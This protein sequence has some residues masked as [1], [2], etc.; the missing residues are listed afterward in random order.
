[1]LLQPRV[2]TRSP[3]ATTSRGQSTSPADGR[4][5][6]NA[7]NAPARLSAAEGR[8]P[9]DGSWFPCDRLA[10][11]DTAQSPWKL[12]G[13]RSLQ[14]MDR[15]VSRDSAIAKPSETATPGRQTFENLRFQMIANTQ[16][17]IV[18]G[19]R[20]NDD[21]VVIDPVPESPIAL[22]H[23]KL[24]DLASVPQR[25]TLS[26]ARTF[27]R[28]NNVAQIIDRGGVRVRLSR[29]INRLVRLAVVKRRFR[30]E[31]RIQPC[32]DHQPSVVNP[33]AQR[34]LSPGH[35][36]RFINSAL[37]KK[38]MRTLRVRE[39]FIDVSVIIDAES[40]RSTRTGRANV[41]EL[42]LRIQESPSHMAR[43]AVVADD[44]TRLVDPENKC[45]S[46][47]DRRSS[48]PSCPRA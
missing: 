32:L 30:T 15:S 20:P 13:L 39:I 19:E 22:G 3:A 38:S 10:G 16:N 28:I 44:R 25:A 8:D 2:S 12:R 24:V 46:P 21:I 36:Q 37:Q 26:V 41:R 18:I 27:P 14:P 34:L 9:R 48:S 40:L 33:S 6:A 35:V 5:P 42:P 47:S 17:P 7:S 11:L 4:R 31:A 23:V 45:P 43:G 1:M 29:H